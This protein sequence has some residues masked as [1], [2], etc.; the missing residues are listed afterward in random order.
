MQTDIIPSRNYDVLIF[1]IDLGADPDPYPFWHS[2]QRS[3]TGLNL[4]NFA[5]VN[6][7]KLLEQ[8][9][10]TGKT[11]DRTKLYDQFNQILDTQ[12]PWLV[13]D[14]PQLEYAIDSSIVGPVSGAGFYATDRFRNVSTWYIK[15]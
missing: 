8:A 6:A 14:H 7:D 13:L 2:S 3:A 9:R 11:T 1:G 12:K 5:D 15:H 4:S 10:K